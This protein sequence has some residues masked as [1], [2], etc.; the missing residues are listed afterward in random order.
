MG[1][2]DTCSIILFSGS[3]SIHTIWG[4]ILITGFKRLIAANHSKRVLHTQQSQ[5]ACYPKIYYLIR[6]LAA[7]GFWK[8]KFKNLFFFC[9]FIL[10]GLLSLFLPSFPF[11]LPFTILC[12]RLKNSSRFLSLDALRFANIIQKV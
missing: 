11:L 2:S 1:L 10:K 7:Q 5:W 8:T 12:L 9:S 6:W 4:L 3:S